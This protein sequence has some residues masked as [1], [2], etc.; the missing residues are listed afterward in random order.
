MLSDLR[1]HHAAGAYIQCQRTRHADARAEAAHQVVN[2]RG[3]RAAMRLQGRKRNDLDRHQDDPTADALHEICPYQRPHADI[4]GPGRHLPA[5]VSEA[6]QAERDQLA[7]IDAARDASADDHRGEKAEAARRLQ[8]AD[9]IDRVAAHMVEEG[10]HQHHRRRA[11]EAIDEREYQAEKE[12]A[13]RQ[14]ARIEERLLRRQAMHVEHVKAQHS[15]AAFCDDFPGFEPVE[16]PA[17]VEHQLQRTDAQRQ[18]QESEP[19]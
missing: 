18:A 4:G 17:A 2:R 13:L 12:I 7:R 6:Q 5:R 11:H 16:L 15:E 8:Q 19:V 9:G 14:Q 1:M 3:L 10:G